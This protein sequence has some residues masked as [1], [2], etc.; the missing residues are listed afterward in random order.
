ML[1]RVDKAQM[2]LLRVL[3]IKKGL[4][5]SETTR[6][7]IAFTYENLAHTY[8]KQGMPFQHVGAIP[9]GSLS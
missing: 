7:D 9:W 4:K 6:T 3:T 8:L 5:V 1:Y 2:A